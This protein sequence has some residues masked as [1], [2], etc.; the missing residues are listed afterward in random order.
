MC[1]A[2]ECCVKPTITPLA[3]CFQRGANN[4]VNAGTKTTPAASSTLPASGSTSEVLRIIP[5]LSRSHCTPAPAIATDP[6]RAYKQLG[7]YRGAS[8]E[9][10]LSPC[11]R[12]GFEPGLSRHAT[13]VSNP[14]SDVTT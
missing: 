4:P 5:R 11:A 2:V 7:A 10:S 12:F 6:S 1:A 9:L 13:V 3:S 8:S 14:C